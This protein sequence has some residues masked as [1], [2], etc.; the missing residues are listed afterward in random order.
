MSP[1]V[2]PWALLALPLAALPF[3]LERLARRRGEPIPFSSLYLLER[4]RRVPT[5]RLSPARWT[6]L[7]RALV[8]ALLVLAA[9]RPVAPGRGDPV[10]HFPTRLVVAVDVSASVRQRGEA[11][12]AWE[13]LRAAADSLL[14]LAG[15][16][17]E[18]ALAALA[19]R[20]V[21]WWEGPAP[22]LRRRLAALEPSARPSDWP[23]A[24]S[25]L[26]SRMDDGTESYL[27]TDGSGGARGPGRGS[28]PAGYRAIWVWDLPS[29]GNRG[30]VSARWLSPERVALAAR[31][32]GA[33]VPSAAVVGH[34]IADRLGEEATLPLAAAAQADDPAPGGAWSVSDT[35]TFAFA[36]PD[37]H[38]FDDR[39]RVAR[40]RAGGPYRVVR[41]TPPDEPAEP[42]ALFWEAALAAAPR[43]AR[44]ER[45]ASLAELATRAPDLAL[46]PLRAYGL[47]EGRLLAELAGRGTRLL[48]APACPDPACVPPPGWLPAL[49]VPDLAWSLGPAERQAAL[50]ARAEAA[51]APPVPDHLMAEV[52]VRG[53]LGVQGGP[54][55]D[56]TWRLTTGAPAFWAR[57]PIALWLVPLGP[58]VTRLATTPVFP[59]VAEAAVSAWDPRWGRGGAGI[60]VGEPIAAPEGATVT[61]PLEA[62]AP[63]TWSVAPGSAPPRPESP[64]FYR[65][66]DVRGEA[67]AASLVAV[68]ADPAEGDLTPVAASAWRAAWGVEPTPRG[69]WD[70]AIFPRRRGPE[71]WPWALALALVALAAEAAVRRTGSHK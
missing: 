65:V 9:A 43:G 51:A 71:L 26:A 34:R 21:G 36:Q 23:A 1:F 2:H 55:P 12:T 70:A 22:D 30:L 63:R 7:L 35:A 68:N 25:A 41:W 31:G 69:G 59:L 24:L 27:F 39:L 37:R 33:G 38:P 16:D 56:L 29:E 14:A 15:P 42:G 48:F 20:L 57:G 66:S 46:L 67:P 52:P 40:G 6:A 3:L 4:A 62:A 45:A 18:V 64:G 11:G 49:E 60:L 17:D 47:A 13:A 44:V 10:A 32:W 28:P 19:D 53:A 50:A 54:V 58:P 8:V 61:G 5:R